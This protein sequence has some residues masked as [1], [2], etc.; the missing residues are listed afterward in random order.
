VEHVKIRNFDLSGNSTFVI[1]EIGNNHDQSLEKAKKLIQLSRECG[2]NAVKFQTFVGK[3]ICTTNQPAKDY[4]FEPANRHEFWHEY[5]DT[6]MLPFEWYDELIALTHQLGMAFISTPCSIERARF[7]KEKGADALKIASMDNN[8]VPFLRDLSK[9]GLPLIIS[10]GMA[11]LSQITLAMDALGF[12]E[13]EDIAIL[14]C[15][16]EYPTA[17]EK[18][19]LRRIQQLQAMFGGVVGFSDHSIKNY[20]AFASI[21]YGAKIIEKHFTDSRAQKGPDH[22]FAQQPED[23]KD[24]VDGIREIEKAIHEPIRVRKDLATKPKM[25]RTL[26]FSRPLK[27]G[28]VITAQDVEIKR[29]SG[30]LEPL[31]YDVVV[32][33]QLKKDV[34]GISPVT[35]TH[36]K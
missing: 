13:K 27:A 30:G 14:H 23:F 9:L 24:L 2:A 7:L 8:H 15:V 17:P 3:D 25:Q 22:F 12:P 26:H 1:S 6:I 21:A 29:P 19:Q 16:S 11:K 35:W 32:G 28:H 33:M 4:Q 5:L 31:F 36:L 10:T 18:I 20:S 34:S